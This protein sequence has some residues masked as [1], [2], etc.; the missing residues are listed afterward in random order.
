MA[1]PAV[2]TPQD[3][4]QSAEAEINAVNGELNDVITRYD[5]ASAELNATEQAIA[6]RTAE[7]DSTEKDLGTARA[8]FDARVK[9]MYKYS[10]VS[11][12][13]VIFGSKSLNDFTERFDLLDRVG[14]S[15]AGLVKR[16]TASK[17]SLEKTRAD[18]EQARAKQETL[19]NQVASDKAAIENKVAAKREH[20]S[21]LEQQAAL[22]EQG[23]RAN[24]DSS[25]SLWH[26]SLPP[27]S[28]GVV[29]IAYALIGVPYVYGGASPEEGFDCSGFVSYCY[30]RIGVYLNRTCDY[31]PNLSWDELEPGDLVFSH[32][33]GHVGIYVGGG[34]QIHAPYPGRYVEES[35][36]YA[37][38]G[39]YRP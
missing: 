2:A 33:M 39:G 13:E 16:V 7:L 32:G 11:A 38:C 18:L 23:R 4:K 20:L 8:T 36:V 25:P 5:A 37:F 29:A 35:P 14:N 3:E 6:E 12:L 22:Q 1:L 30:S 9:G 17:Q 27:A 19:F 15:D 31:S 24:S 34:M 28:S 26:G 10:D 21:E